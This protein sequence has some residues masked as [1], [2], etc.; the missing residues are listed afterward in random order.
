MADK[1]AVVRTDLM[2]GTDD[3]SQLVS[4]KYLGADG[5]T[6]TAIDNGNILKVGDLVKGEREVY[7]GAVPEASTALKDIVLVASPEVLYDEHKKNLDDFVNEA[8][9]ICR[10][11]RL[12]Q[13]DGFSVTAA[14]LDG[15][16]AVGKTVNIDAGTKMKVGGTGTK[17]G[18]IKEVATA[19][20]YT[21]YY[22][23]ID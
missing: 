22:I 9:T 18:T 23:V 2:S 5:N 14:A 8:G 11:Y 19:G 16:P 10:G 6:P 17:I 3:R 21:Y 1:H 13:H 12:H 4:I 20:R 15:E 7:V